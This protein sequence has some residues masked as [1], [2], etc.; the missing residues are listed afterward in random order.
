VTNCLDI[1]R[2]SY[3]SVGAQESAFGEQEEK[4]QCANAEVAPEGRGDNDRDR[5]E[6]G[7]GGG[8]VAVGRAEPTEPALRGEQP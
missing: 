3:E 7:Q 4:E 6:R 2:E 5:A 8:A 1:E